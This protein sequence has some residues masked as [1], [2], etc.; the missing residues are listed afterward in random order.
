MCGNSSLNSLSS[1]MPSHKLRF[2]VGAKRVLNFY[3]FDVNRHRSYCASSVNKKCMKSACLEY[4]CRNV[5]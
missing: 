5:V 3:E 2:G 4:F 1:L